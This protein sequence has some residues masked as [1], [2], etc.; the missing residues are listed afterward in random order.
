MHRLTLFTVGKVKTPWILDGCQM[1]IDRLKHSCDFREQILSSGSAVEEHERLSKALSKIDGAIVLLDERGKMMTSPG[2]AT[3]I[4]SKRDHGTP[5]TFCIGGAYGFN[6]ALRSTA[7]MVLSLSSMTFP[8]E[9]CK[10]LF[11]EQLFRAE[12]ILAGSGYHHG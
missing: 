7:S 11:L 4:S 8:H 10:L 1:Y 12:S 5:I 6:D 9:L 2:L 3:F